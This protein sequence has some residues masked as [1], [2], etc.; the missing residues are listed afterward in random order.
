MVSDGA[1]VHEGLS[2]DREDGVHVVRHLDVK[3]EL[4][5]LNDVDPETQREAGDKQNGTQIGLL[6]V[7]LQLRAWG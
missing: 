5:V 7:N 6:Q 3:D 1:G 2:D 4:R